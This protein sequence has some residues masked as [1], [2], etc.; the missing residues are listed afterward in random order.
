LELTEMKVLDILGK[1][2]THLVNVN[3]QKE[4]VEVDLSELQK[5]I[6][7]IKTAS[8]SNKVYKQ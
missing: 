1:D 2:I 5:G 7:F 8:A 4:K 3:L 6:Y